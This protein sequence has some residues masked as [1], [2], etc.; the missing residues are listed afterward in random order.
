M[1]TPPKPNSTI[2]WDW[3]DWA[4][5]SA[6]TVRA[7]KG[8]AIACREEH[9]LPRH[10]QRAITEGWKAGVHAV[11]VIERIE[12]GLRQYRIAPKG[13][14]LEAGMC[15]KLISAKNHERA[16]DKFCVQYFGPLKP[17]RNDWIVEVA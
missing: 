13:K 2:A 6:V 5:Q 3:Y 10:C 14:G 12:L 1:R 15:E 9:R 16:W 8:Q 4:L 11:E 7:R 17:D